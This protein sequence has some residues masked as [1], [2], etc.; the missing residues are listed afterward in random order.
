MRGRHTRQTL[1]SASGFAG[2]AAGRV[3]SRNE[4]FDLVRILAF[5]AIVFLH[6]GATVSVQE[7]PLAAT[8][9]AVARFAVPFFF[10]VTGFFLARADARKLTRGFRKEL[11]FTACAVALYFALAAF[12]LWDW[13]GVGLPILA[14]FERDW[15]GPFLL[16]NDFPFAYHLW[17]LFAALYVYAIL[18][19]WRA[20]RAPMGV[21]LVLGAALLVIR[22]FLT[23]FTGTLD[24]LGMQ[25][26]S[27]LFFAL[28]SF[29]LGM[30]LARAK[31]R[32]RATPVAASL[33][34]IVGG[35]ILSVYEARL[36]GLQELYIGSIVTVA[37]LFALCLRCPHPFS[38]VPGLRRI[39]TLA[40]FGGMPMGIAYVVHLA[41]LQAM[42][43]A[44]EVD[45]LTAD[46]MVVI[47][48]WLGC[49]AVSLAVGYACSL[50]LMILRRFFHRAG[51]GS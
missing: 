21:F 34:A 32:L 8:V 46:P 39:G 7:T 43:R 17:F 24:P 25:P 13:S 42:L 28:P 29:A 40:R 44:S 41:I 14:F 27:F 15:V 20:C 2:T 22:L 3:P 19:V 5:A 33:I 35:S 45:P 49:A 10:A 4:S 16:W 9:N 26:R 11:V 37:G 23:E 47:A 30:A 18:I 51:E 50:A 12:G 31:D 1:S 36:F 6:M 38:S 48:V